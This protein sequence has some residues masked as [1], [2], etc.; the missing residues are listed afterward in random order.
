MSALSPRIIVALALSAALFAGCTV[1]KKS[2][3]PLSGPSGVGLSLSLTASP[4]V[5]PRDGSS[6]STIT[7]SA[8]N[9]DGSA[10][11]Q[12]LL[13]S[14]SAGA[15]SATD[16][17]TNASG[18]ATVQ[19]TAPPLNQ[20]VTSGVISAQPVMS[21]DTGTPTSLAR[22]VTV[23]FTGPGVPVPDFTPSTTAPGQY[24]LVTFDA[25]KTTLNN[26]PCG[27]TCTYVFDFGD[28]SNSTGEVVTHR[29]QSQGT[30]VVTLTASAPGGTSSTKSEAIT[31]GTPKAL[32]AVITFSPSSPA[33]NVDTVNFSGTGSSTPDGATISSY[34]WD[35]G[36]G[37]TGTGATASMLYTSPNTYTVRL[38]ITDSLGRTATTTAA[39]TVK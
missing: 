28:G 8:K 39:V 13:L 26:A 3:P 34:A 18:L 2:T 38:T 5:L 27:N 17:T 32:T 10:A 22:T 37:Q 9:V 21:T 35:F 11:Q 20:P 36:N 16:V 25:S 1:Q 6:V 33:A 7:I 29:Y 14:A 19:L 12:R 31:V 4:D 23:T 15:L 30:F 24:D